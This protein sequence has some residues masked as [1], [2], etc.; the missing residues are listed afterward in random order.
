MAYLIKI[1][2][3]LRQKTWFITQKASGH[4]ISALYSLTDSHYRGYRA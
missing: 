1:L 4:Q 2:M 3:G